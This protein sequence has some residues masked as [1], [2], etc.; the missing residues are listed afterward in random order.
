ME[1][2]EIEKD[3][4]PYEFDIV[5]GGKTY[6]FL[7]NY[8]AEYGFFTVDLH[9]NGNLI[10]AGEK[11]VYGRP[12]FFSCRHLEI[13]TIPILPYDM[14]GNEAQVTWDNLNETVFLWLVSADG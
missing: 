13:P 8:N 3:L 5:I 11:I 9:R 1:Y 12:L 10:V 14:S 2:V 6:T 4:I 7:L